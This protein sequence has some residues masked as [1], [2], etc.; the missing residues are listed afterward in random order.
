MKRALSLFLALA[1]FCALAGPVLAEDSDF[2][3]ENGILVGYS[4]PGGD[5][6]IPD[7]VTEIA[8]YL[9][10]GNYKLTG[11][12]IPESMTKLG[13]SCFA[14]CANLVSVTIPESLT[15]MG[16]TAFCNTPWLAGLGDFPAVNGILLAYNGSDSAVTIPQGVKEI[17]A[18][19]FSGNL[20]LTSVVIPEGVT[21]VG[22]GAFSQCT[23]LSD[24]TV[25]QSLT[26]VSGRA[27]ADTPWVTT[28]GEFAILAGVLLKYNGSGGAVTVP[29]GVKVIDAAAFQRV[30]VTSVTIPEGVTEIRGNVAYG[31]AFALLSCL[32]RVAIPRSLTNIGMFAF[33]SCGIT[34]VY[35]AGTEAEWTALRAQLETYVWSNQPLFDAAIHYNSGMPSAET[36]GGFSDVFS[37]D[38]FAEAVLWAVNHDPQ[39]TNGIGGGKFGATGTVTRAQ[40]VTFL[41]RAAGC[42][43]PQTAVSPFS[44]VSDP[45]AWYYKAV[46]WAAE[47]NITNGVGGGK[48]GLNG[49]LAYDQMLTFMARAAGADASGGDWSEKAMAWAEASG[50]TEGLTVTAKGDCPR[51]DAVYCLWKQ[52]A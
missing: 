27:F 25:P 24:V 44:D 43:E 15:D 32:T 28:L 16:Y 11:V 12:T 49:T 7:G 4:G 22:Y 8:S 2:K 9:F 38:H 40:A 18:G 30:P 29:D 46:L 33:E 31:G 21:A 26:A 13:E 20:T 10:N 3:V 52:M 19:A 1:L 36:V 34:D 45:G 41:W 50:L 42:P 23:A 39:I 5:I 17:G 48:F 47:Q 6:V 35:Y 51:C 14:N 37:T